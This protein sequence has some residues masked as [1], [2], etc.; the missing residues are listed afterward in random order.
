M[1]NDRLSERKSCMNF[2]MVLH[3]LIADVADS[4][5][6][7]TRSSVI[8]IQPNPQLLTV[9]LWRLSDVGPTLQFVETQQKA[10]EGLQI[11]IERW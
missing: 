7:L 2:F 5:A 1:S 4:P 10:I 9:M 6:H 8:P 3:S 11:L